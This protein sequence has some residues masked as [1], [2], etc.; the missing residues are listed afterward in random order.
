VG[1]NVGR[2]VAL[3]VGF[4]KGPGVAGISP[5]WDA[6]AVRGA[7]PSGGGGRG[8]GLLVTTMFGLGVAR[9]GK[10]VALN[11]GRAVALAVGVAEGLSVVGKAL[12]W[13]GDV[14]GLAVRRAVGEAVVGR[15]VRRTGGGGHTPA[16]HGMHVTPLRLVGQAERA[17]SAGHVW[18]PIGARQRPSGRR[19]QP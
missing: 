13:L 9:V 6:P 19:T 14:V 8:V 2:A 4:V 1:L 7:V 17:Q 18:M 12:R 11:V 5:R 3:A 16:K 15:G 10:A